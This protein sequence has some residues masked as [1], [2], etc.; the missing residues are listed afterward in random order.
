MRQ[1][2]SLLIV[3]FFVYNAVAQQSTYKAAVVEY[4][5]KL[6][7]PS[8]TI[9][10]LENVREYIDLME[11]AAE[12][13]V[14]II[15]FPED[16]LTGWEGITHNTVDELSTDVPDPIQQIT[17]CASTNSNYSKFFVDLSCAA[18]THRIYTVVNLIERQYDN[19]TNKKIYH[20]TNVV[21]NR[22]GV[23]VAKYR[24][25]NLFN[26]PVFVPGNTI[27][28]FKTDFG[29]TFGMFICFDIMFKNPALDV[30]SNPEVTDVVYSAAW[31]SELPFYGAL[32]I[33]DGFAKS[34][35]IN[36][37]ASGLDNPSQKNGGSGIYLAN[38]SIAEVHMSGAKTTKML[39]Q[40][41]PING[42]KNS[43]DSC[44]GASGATSPSVEPRAGPG[45]GIGVLPNISN[46]I[47]SEENTVNY[48]FKSLNL[49]KSEISETICSG[50]NFCCSFNITVKRDT[51]VQLNYVYKLLAYYGVSQISSNRS[52]GLR[53][54]ALVACLNDT[55]SSCGGRH[56]QS[57]TGVTFES[58]SVK[59]NFNP[60]T[61]HAQPATLKANLQPATDYKYCKKTISKDQVEIQMT[62]TQ[63][64]E[65]I[66]TFGIHGRVFN[67]DDKR[68]GVI[69]SATF[70][71]SN[72]YFA[73]L[74]SIIVF[75][76][77]D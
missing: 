13:G 27:V 57:P 74:I 26:E 64:Q 34:T 77:Q 60:Q 29:V 25:I 12:K 5:P 71:I 55:N 52:L 65:S 67:Y 11:Q 10:I 43:S 45:F 75:L 22:N 6:T 18:E 30:L 68:G 44:K 39:I 58:I 7:A 53:N 41:V 20:N 73:P 49:D 3:Q 47:T 36:L 66:L 63:R 70:L 32:S 2:V 28:T 31:F 33:Q 19:K 40:D 16:G 38:G 24:K 21:F 46:F 56:K 37:L 42:A 59:G 1:L 69:N 35:G 14:Q 48:T 17:P 61:S 8:L 72:V 23:V 76:L 54:C 62:T 51:N 9:R 50:S 15:V 4:S